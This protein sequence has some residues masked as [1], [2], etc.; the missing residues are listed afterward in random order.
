MN[1]HNVIA[2]SGAQGVIGPESNANSANSP[3]SNDVPRAAPLPLRVTPS[4]DESNEWLTIEQLAIDP[5]Q[6][7]NI[8]IRS[9]AGSNAPGNASTEAMAALQD[10][11]PLT[12]D[13]VIKQTV[14]RSLR[15]TEGNRRRSASM[16]GISRS[17]LYRMLS[18]YGIDHVGRAKAST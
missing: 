2:D 18:R 9:V 16:L 3:S 12:L 15:K 14:I 11:W 17:T 5:G 4:R 1:P 6:A 13:E 8:K 7:R 10:T